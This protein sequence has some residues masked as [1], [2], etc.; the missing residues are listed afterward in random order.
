MCV[1]QKVQQASCPAGSGVQCQE[2]RASPLIEAQKG[3]VAAEN[4]L[5]SQIG[6]DVLVDG[7]SA[8]DAAIASV[9]C[10]GTINSFSSGIGGGGFMLV[11]DTNGTGL[12]IDFRETAPAA[13]THDMFVSRPGASRVGGLAVAV[14]GELR[15]LE[16]AHRRFGKLSWKRLFEP[17][18]R[19]NRYGFQITSLLA[20]HLKKLEPV[21]MGVPGLREIFA[22]RG[23]LLQQGET[24]YRT[25]L[26]NTLELVADKGASA[27]Y[28]GQ[29]ARE[30]AQAVRARGGIMTTA[31]LAAYRPNVYPPLV[32]SYR[33][34]RVLTP[35]A[36][37]SGPVFHE[38]L[39][40]LEGYSLDSLPWDAQR[41]HWI[42][43]SFK[44]GFAAR[45]ELGDPAFVAVAE[46]VQ[47]MMDK[48]AA[49]ALR[50][51]ISDG[52]TFDPMYYNPQFANNEPHGTTHVIALD[53]GGQA[54]SMMSTVNLYFGSQVVSASTGVILNNEM[55]DFSTPGTSNAFGLPASP[56]NFIA[57]GKRP[58][59]SSVPVIVDV[60]GQFEFAAGAS[61]GSRII[62]SVLQTLVNSLDYQLQLDLAVDAPRMHHQLS[63]NVLGLEATYNRTVAEQLA[64]RGHVLAWSP[65]E[66]SQSAVQAIRRLPD[67]RIHAV[68]DGRKHGR[69]AGY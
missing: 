54:V 31:D 14:P 6:V 46:Q 37:T 29:I 32:G 9:L 66:V 30:I 64:S 27:F 68:S 43:E 38:I 62:T 58:L 21:I 40:I 49:S 34:K 22:P 42:V 7:G 48:E 26:A 11:R 55:D 41:Q 45:S 1:L 69:A 13:A 28:T 53:H 47:R 57:P 51:N 59:S 39:N 15:G 3:A 4:P 2:I 12:V 17:S 19:L 60:D 65:R 18:I 52:R 36:P 25:A 24:C 50:R 63:P 20:D 44:H 8:V 5:C 23:Q 61:G 35:N 67:G 10:I 56:N 16:A 33:G